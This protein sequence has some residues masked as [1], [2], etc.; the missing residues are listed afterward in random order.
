MCLKSMRD[1]IAGAAL[2]A[3]I[4]TGCAEW[5]GEVPAVPPL[6][7][8]TPSPVITPTPALGGAPSVQSGLA[9]ETPAPTAPLWPTPTSASPPTALLGPTSTPDPLAAAATGTEAAELRAPTIVYFVASPEEAA[10][11]EPV[12]L[13]W[14]SRE[15]TEAAVFQV[16]ED[17]TP[18]RA[19]AVEPEGS[20]MVSA[21]VGG[22]SMSYVLTV[23]NGIAT[24]E[25][26]LVVRVTCPYTWFFTPAPGELCPDRDPSRSQAS[27]QE[28]EHGRM[29]WIAATGQI[30]VLFDE[31]PTQPD[32]T[33][34]A[35][36]VE[37]N[38]YVEGQPED[39]PSIQP[40]EGFAKPR[41]GFG[42]VWRDTPSVR[43]RL[44]WAVSD[45]VPFVTTYQSAHVGDAAQ[46]YFSNTLGEAIAL[47]SEGR[48]W[49]VVGFEEGTLPPT[50]TP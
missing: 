29:F 43:E 30:I 32:Q 6:P 40:P 1:I 49:L 23:T 22:S 7:T 3:L 5:L 38:P 8:L 15:G 36:L 21:D 26:Q 34:P 24:V 45:E 18:G 25:Q 42:L 28:F 44:G 50:P 13:L 47:I 9:A 11:G 14:S 41:R 10:P 39:D 12:L 2:A 19:W 35:W 48:G 46:F 37:T 4:T 27:T 31:L 20:L 17:G 33:L 16:N